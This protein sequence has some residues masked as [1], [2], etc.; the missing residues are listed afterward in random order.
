MMSDI[1]KLQIPVTTTNKTI[2]TEKVKKPRVITEED[3]WVLEKEDYDSSHQYDILFNEKKS[4]Q[5]ITVH[6]KGYEY[7]DYL[8]KLAQQQVQRKINGY[9]TQDVE[10][11]LLDPTEFIDMSTVMQ[12]L[13]ESNMSCMYCK[14]GVQV[15]Y[16]LVREPKQWSLDRIDNAV[17]HN[18]NNVVIACLKCNL[19][20]RCIYHEKFVFTKHLNIVK[21]DSG[22]PT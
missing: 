4:E 18:K 1:K 17:G 8:R 3:V 22:E 6:K 19:K 13:K 14:E 15:L 20:R 7:Y 12:L 10:K 2:K 5:H 21:Q 11:K 9:H 16:Q